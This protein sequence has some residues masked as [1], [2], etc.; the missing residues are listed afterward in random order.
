MKCCPTL[1]TEPSRSTCRPEQQQPQKIAGQRCSL[2]S[3]R[4]SRSRR[5]RA[6]AKSLGSARMVVNPQTTP[7]STHS[8]PRLSAV[9]WSSMQAEPFFSRVPRIPEHHPLQHNATHARTYLLRVVRE[10]PLL[11][12]H[13]VELQ[14][15]LSTLHHLERTFTRRKK[16]PRN[17]ARHAKEAK[18][19]MPS[20]RR[21][22]TEQAGRR[23]WNGTRGKRYV[24][25]RRREAE[26]RL[27]GSATL[28]R[29]LIL[30]CAFCPC[31]LF[32]LTGL[33]LLFVSTTPTWEN[34]TTL[35][36]RC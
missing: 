34:S 29:C 27:V 5:L 6:I 13:G 11:H 36:V 33:K 18:R 10:P 3:L 16:Q 8:S 21:K 28:R 30:S 17:T 19:W 20:S 23:R 24:E 15:L 22:Y 14:L 32:S 25:G 2:F 1:P 4:L 31:A 12:D 26:V 9:L 35:A 7:R